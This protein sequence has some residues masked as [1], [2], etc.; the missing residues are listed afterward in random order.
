MT[1]HTRREFLS[2]LFSTTATC[3]LSAPLLNLSTEEGDDD[4]IQ[5]NGWILKKSDLYV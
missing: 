5:V 4:F 3:F 1:K 2:F